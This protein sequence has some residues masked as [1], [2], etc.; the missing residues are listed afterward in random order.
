MQSVVYQYTL[1]ISIRYVDHCIGIFTRNDFAGPV[2]PS[3]RLFVLIHCFIR[4]FGA[5]T[6]VAFTPYM[7]DPSA[8]TVIFTEPVAPPRIRLMI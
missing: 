3:G 8:N 4:A 2:Y 5:Q 6:V 7:R 1:S